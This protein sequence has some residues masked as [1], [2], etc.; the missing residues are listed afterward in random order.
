MAAQADESVVFVLV[1][2]YYTNKGDIPAPEAEISPVA[3]RR[4]Q[5]FAIGNCLSCV[6]LE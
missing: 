6:T 5:L 2:A 4:V 1:Q 3:A